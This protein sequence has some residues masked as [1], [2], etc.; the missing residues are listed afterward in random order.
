M[1]IKTSKELKTV[2][3]EEKFNYFNREL[4]FL[5]ELKLAFEKNRIWRIWQLQK[6]MRIIEYKQN[7][8]GG[9]KPFF[10]TLCAQKI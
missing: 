4:S 6:Q 10:T 5:D 1:V 3:K 2:L 8:S 7:K 9:G